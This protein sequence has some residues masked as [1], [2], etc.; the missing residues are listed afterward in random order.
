MQ[1]AGYESRG[2]LPPV[3]AEAGA[4]MADSVVVKSLGHAKKQ[5]SLLAG[6][7]AHALV[8]RFE[9]QAQGSPDAVRVLRGEGEL[10]VAGCGHGHALWE[11]A[12]VVEVAYRAV[13]DEAGIAIVCEHDVELAYCGAC[14]P[15]Q[16][17]S[18]FVAVEKPDEP[19]L[20]FFGEQALEQFWIVFRTLPVTLAVQQ[21]WRG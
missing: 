5:C 14:R 16:A 4:E 21:G 19:A 20:Y 15:V 7:H 12:P 10:N 1:D 6:V 2:A 17:G 11:R 13:E 18:G 9:V 3:R 8:R